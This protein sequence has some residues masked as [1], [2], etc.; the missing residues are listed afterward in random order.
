VTYSASDLCTAYAGIKAQFLA[1]VRLLQTQNTD[2]SKRVL[3]SMYGK[4]VW[5]VFHD[6]VDLDITK[7]DFMGADGYIGDALVAPA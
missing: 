2:A 7:P 1:Q 4:V 3:A 5:M 6:A